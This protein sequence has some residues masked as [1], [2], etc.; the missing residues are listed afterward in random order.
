MGS[1]FGLCGSQSLPSEL[2][3]GGGKR[4]SEAKPWGWWKTGEGSWN[5]TTL[6]QRTFQ[7]GEEG[8]RD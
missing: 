4:G 5:S 2:A 3:E 1:V 7:S 6:I 8:G